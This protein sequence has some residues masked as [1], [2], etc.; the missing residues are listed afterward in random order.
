MGA[1]L[2]PSSIIAEPQTGMLDLG[3][4]G[5]FPDISVLKPIETNDKLEYLRA[6]HTRLDML[7]DIESPDPA[8]ADWDALFIHEYVV[9]KY[10]MNHQI[11]FSRYTMAGRRQIMGQDG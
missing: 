1:S 8:K 6:Y 11:S 3:T 5:L 9:R 2:I 10:L 4:D 7:N